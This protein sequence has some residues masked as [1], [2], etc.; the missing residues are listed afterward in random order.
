L[1]DWTQIKLGKFA[2]KEEKFNLHELFDNV[3]E[4]IKFKADIK[5]IFCDVELERNLPVMVFG[6]QQR[7]MQ[8]VINLMSNALKFTFFGGVKTKVKYL[9]P[10]L[11]VSV[12]DTGD[13]MS[14]ETQ[15]NL[16]KLFGT[17]SS[18]NERNIGGIGLGLC[19]CKMLVEQFG[20]KIDC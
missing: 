5:Q 8:I 11:E 17:K 3:C 18:K 1:V 15:K 10:L 19:I 16:F 4:M 9:N 12:T 6:D 20:G 13:G 7:L 2:K 14:L